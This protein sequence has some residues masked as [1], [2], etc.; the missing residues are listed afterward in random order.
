MSPTAATTAGTSAGEALSDAPASLLESM[1]PA[2]S[3]NLLKI[4]V[5]LTVTL[6][7]KKQPIR[8]IVNLGPGSI[9]QFNKSCEE[10]LEV[11]LAGRIVAVGE[12]VKVGDKF[13]VRLT[14]IVLP[15]ERLVA[16]RAKP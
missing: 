8:Q 1:A 7:A 3:R 15:D 16:L 10:M 12:A 5:P 6:A 4:E 11:E 2:Y 9:I 14:S 13:G